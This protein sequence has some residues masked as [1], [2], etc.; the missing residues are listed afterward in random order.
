MPITPQPNRYPQ[1]NNGFTLIE[2]LVVLAILALVTALGAQTLA[3]RPTFLDRSQTLERLKKAIS[4]AHEDAVRTGKP[5]RVRLEMLVT[6]SAST[7]RPAVG[8][9]KDG[10]IFYADGS[11][12]GGTISLASHP[13]LEVDWLTGQATNAKR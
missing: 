12:N 1:M 8:N 7:F 3:V 4:A 13:I 6:G 5:V 9:G 11:S 2:L 10:L